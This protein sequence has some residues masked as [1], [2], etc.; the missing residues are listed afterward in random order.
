MGVHGVGEREK[1]QN[2]SVRNASVEADSSEAF[3]HEGDA[4]LPLLLR[5]HLHPKHHPANE[6]RTLEEARIDLALTEKARNEALRGC[7]ARGGYEWPAGVGW[8]SRA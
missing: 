5:R 6:R 2:L 8:R 1:K 4:T 3:E 7:G